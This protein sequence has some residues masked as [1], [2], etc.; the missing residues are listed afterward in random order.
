[1][2]REGSGSQPGGWEGLGD[3]SGGPGGVVRPSWSAG[4]AQESLNSSGSGLEALLKVWK[5]NPEGQGVG[6][7]TRRSE[8]PTRRSGSGWQ[9][10]KEVRK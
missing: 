1:M 9:A 2:V 10:H 4:K 8:N 5:A 3:T 7:L 6:R